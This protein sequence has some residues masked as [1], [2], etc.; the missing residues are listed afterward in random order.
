MPLR[1]RGE[2]DQILVCF[3]A[4]AAGCSSFNQWRTDVD[5]SFGIWAVRLPGRES[6]FAEK[7]ISSMAG[8]VQGLAAAIDELPPARLVFVG[9]CL[10]A[11]VAY[12]LTREMSRHGREDR[13]PTCLVTVGQ[14]SPDTPVIVEKP[15]A[16]LSLAELIAMLKEVGVTPSHL[17]DQERLMRAMAATIRADLQVG[18]DYVDSGQQP[19][20]KIPIVALR[21]DRDALASLHAVE[22]W[23][24][25]TADEFYLHTVR[26]GHGFFQ[27]RSEDVL[28]QLTHR[29]KAICG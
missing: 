6:R 14:P 28:S 25:F 5:P 20:L 27:E 1:A 12:E 13:M 11:L 4:A 26:G 8:I 17:L 21:G 2:S 18:A 15:I 16:D 24:R 19:P 7:P 29:L 3:P 10:G 22:S 9:H 23:S